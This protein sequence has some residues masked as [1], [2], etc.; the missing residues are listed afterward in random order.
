MLKLPAEVRASYDISSMRVAIHAAAPCPVDVKQAM[1]DWWGPIL[2]EYYSSTEMNGLAAIGPQEWLEK[3][4]SVGRAALGTLHICDENGAEL[5]PGEIGTIYFERDSLPFHYHNDPDKTRSA[6]HPEHPTW[7]AVGDLGYVDE[8]GYLFLTDRKAFMI[9]SG[10]VN[11]YP[12]EIEDVLVVHAAVADAAVIGVPDAEMGEQVKAVVQLAD[13]VEA[14]EALEQ[15]L[16][17]YVKAQIARFKAPRSVDFV[18]RLPRTPTGKLLK[19]ELRKQYW[20][21]PTG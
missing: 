20:P 10:G 6:Q 1:M 12:Q 13:G 21:V 11:I 18:D 7:T 19:G 14:S 4:G 8:D 5:G 17:D 9:I 3:P 15:E 16:I 2:H